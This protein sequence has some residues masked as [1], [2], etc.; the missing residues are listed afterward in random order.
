MGQGWF[1]SQP[2][3]LHT[4]ALIEVRSLTVNNRLLLQQI[5]GLILIVL[6]STGCAGAETE[7]IATSEVPTATRV[8]PTATPTPIRGIDI[9]LSVQGI[10]L[11][12]SSV[13]Q[14][15]TYQTSAGQTFEPV[16]ANDV[17]LI[18][19]S[20]VLSGDVEGILDWCVSITD[21]KGRETT[22]GL[23]TTTR[24]DSGR[25]NSVT[26]LFV[27]TRA[28]RLFTLHLPDEQTISLDPLLRN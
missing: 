5:A 2:L 28:S 8:T 18:V 19:E 6:S 22:P 24:S 15:D 7:A 23:S 14:Q 1:K 26:W 3:A 10:E 16:A 9:P 20:A 17:F 12:I 25:G 27:V 11:Q 21:D 13:T 4:V